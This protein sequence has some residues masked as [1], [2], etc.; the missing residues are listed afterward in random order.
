MRGRA[1]QHFLFPVADLQQLPPSSGSSCLR[2]S[3]SCNVNYR[4]YGMKGGTTA[5]ENRKWSAGGC[6]RQLRLIRFCA[7]T[8]TGWKPGRPTTKEGGMSFLWADLQWCLLVASQN[9][10]SQP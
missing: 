1:N 10:L 3:L 5:A 7:T 8:L 9:L 4:F 6:A 2:S